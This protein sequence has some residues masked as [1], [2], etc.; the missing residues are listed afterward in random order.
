MRIF[1]LLL[2]AL[3]LAAFCASAQDKEVSAKPIQYTFNLPS[4][5]ALPKHMRYSRYENIGCEIT[6]FVVCDGLVSIEH[7]SLTIT[8][9]TDKDG[10]DISKDTRGRDAWKSKGASTTT[11]DGNTYA[12]FSIF[13]PTGAPMEVPVVKGTITAKVAGK[14]EAQFLNFKTAE[15]GV[16]Q[17]AGPFTFAIADDTKED[18]ED[19]ANLRIFRG[20]KMDGR[21]GGGLDITMEGDRSMIK[22][23]TLND[24]G[25]TLRAMGMGS[26]RMS[27]STSFFSQTTKNGQTDTTK[28]TTT[29]SFF[30]AP[31]TPEFTLTVTFYTEMLDV[32]IALGQE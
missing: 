24:G 25:K 4:I 15:K 10:K 29:Y 30:P 8:A 3:L 13:V 9:V 19:N 26:T 27:S 23:V 5:D 1:K 20:G 18:A 6:Y 28:Q 21:A 14:T 12:T 17:K 31:T 11:T 7:D 2:P 32:T 22:D 16:A